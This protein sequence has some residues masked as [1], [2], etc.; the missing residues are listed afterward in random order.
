MLVTFLRPAIG[1]YGRA[2]PGDILEIA[3]DV[4]RQLLAAGVVT[5]ARIMDVEA[6]LPEVPF[7]EL[8]HSDSP[9][10]SS[11]RT[12]VCVVAPVVVSPRHA[13]VARGTRRRR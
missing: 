5:E 1:Y 7:R 4:A 13:R 8:C 12:S 9:P 2:E 10:A 11:P 3:D 6:A